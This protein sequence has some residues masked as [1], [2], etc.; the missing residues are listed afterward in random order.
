MLGPFQDFADLAMQFG[1]ATMFIVAYPLATIL[2][3]VNDYVLLRVDAWKLCQLCRRPE[4]RSCEDIGTW[5]SI[6][7][8]I[9]IAAV[10]VNS[11]LIAFTGTFAI[12]QNWTGRVWIF[13]G[14]SAGILLAKYLT[15]IYVPD[16]SDETEIQ[17]RRGE[18]IRSKV[19]DNVPDDLE[20]DLSAVSSKAEYTIRIIDDDP[21]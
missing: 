19:V 1:Y 5:Y 18:Y 11:G 17:L 10:F 4:P 16:V 13:L 6:F 2:S 14:T 3:F 15:A 8:I 21:L 20:P 9:S 7:E 12:N